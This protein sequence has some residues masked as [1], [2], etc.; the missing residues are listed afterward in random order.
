[1][2]KE[3]GSCVFQVYVLRDAYLVAFM[4]LPIKGLIK[5]CYVLCSLHVWIKIN[6]S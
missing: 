6:D 3:I 1:M 2:V 5:D 4:C